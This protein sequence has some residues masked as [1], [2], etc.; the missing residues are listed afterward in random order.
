MY[1]SVCVIHLRC[2]KVNMS[3]YHYYLTPQ[4][5]ILLSFSTFTG[6]FAIITNTFRCSP[7]LLPLCAFFFPIKQDRMEI[8]ASCSSNEIQNSNQLD[9]NVCWDFHLF[10]NIFFLIDDILF[11]LFVLLTAQW[12]LRMASTTTN[13]I[14][15]C[16]W[17]I[18][19]E[20]VKVF[21]KKKMY[22]F[23]NRFLVSKK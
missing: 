12:P 1:V 21:R 22:F 15:F 9:L 10:C 2:L 13:F 11:S 5:Y 20:L 6:Y 7:F 4:R 3:S 19:N 8:A 17:N 14:F 23:I 16:L 18:Y